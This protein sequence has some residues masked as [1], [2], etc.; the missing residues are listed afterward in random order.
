MLCHT[1]QASV[2]VLEATPSTGVQPSQV[3]LDSVALISNGGSSEAVQSREGFKSTASPLMTTS[4]GKSV[5]GLLNCQ[6][7]SAPGTQVS[8]ECLLHS[9]VQGSVPQAEGEPMAR[10]TKEQDHTSTHTCSLLLLS[11]GHRK[12]RAGLP[13]CN[14]EHKPS[15]PWSCKG[16]QLCPAG[17]T[18][19]RAAP[20]QVLRAQLK[21]RMVSP[22]STLPAIQEHLICAKTIIRFCCQKMQRNLERPQMNNGVE[23]IPLVLTAVL[24]KHTALIVA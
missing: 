16:A 5:I 8:I 17:S 18:Q 15:P 23:T 2:R 14:Q 24:H 22:W 7:T 20:G 12:P 11:P 21:P 19:H 1:T 6:K 3:H 9:L 4:S 13:T 10:E